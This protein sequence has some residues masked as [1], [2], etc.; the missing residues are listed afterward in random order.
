M[1]AE[2]AGAFYEPI[3]CLSNRPQTE[4]TPRNHHWWIE[5]DCRTRNVSSRRRFLN[6]HIGLMPNSLRWMKFLTNLTKASRGELDIRRIRAPTCTTAR[7]KK[8]KHAKHQISCKSELRWRSRSFLR[9][10]G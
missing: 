4:T 9:A 5:E 2:P 3:P 10:E 6:L 1:I 8:E 7:R